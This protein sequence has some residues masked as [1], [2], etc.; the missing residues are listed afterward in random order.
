MRT[1][2]HVGLFC[3]FLSALAGG[4]SSSVDGGAEED[5]GEVANS[6]C[7]AVTV[8]SNDADDEAVPGQS[9]TWTGTPTCS[10]SAQYQFWFR[11]PQTGVWGLAQDWSSTNTYVWNT[12]GLV[13]GVWQMQLWVRDLPAG[14]FQAYVSHPF[15]LSSNA[16]CTAVSSSR[17]PAAGVAGTSVTFANSASTCPGPEYAIYRMAPGGSW[18]LQSAY[19]TANANYVWNSTGAATGVHQFQIWARQQGSAKSY[20]AY[21]STNFTVLSSNP[22]TSTNLTFSPVGHAPAGTAV[23]LNATAAGCAAP[24]FRY[25]L[26]PAASATW[27]ELQPYTSSATAT[28]NTTLLTP[29]TYNFQ[30]WARN[31]GSTQQFQAYVSK[32]YTLDVST[33]P[34]SLAIGGGYA[35]NCTILST[36]KVGCWGY[37]AKGELGNGTIGGLSKTPVAVTGL[38]SGISLGVGYEHG[39]AVNVGGT[40]SCWGQNLHGQLGNGG[41][42]NSGSPVA[43]SGITNARNIQSGNSHNCVALADGTVKCWGFNSQGQ[44]GDGSKVDRTT[45]VSVPGITT[46]QAVAAGYYHSCALLADGSVQCW[47][48]GGS[49]GNGSAVGSLMPVTVSGL[50]GVTSINASSGN[51]CAVKS[52]GTIWCWG[53]NSAY[54][55]LGN[56]T[57]TAQL[58]PVQ[59]TG[60]TTATAVAVGPYHACAALQNGTATCWGYNVYGQLGNGT[61]V[62]SLAP[63]A[64]SNLTTVK[65]VG[66]AQFDSCAILTDGSARCWGYN[67][68][69]SLGNNSTAHSSVPVTVAAIP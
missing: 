3:I 40:V 49:L 35:Q 2:Q 51:T 13:T 38:T 19:S 10:G 33:T 62:D 34:G 20:Q 4:C 58:S 45:P 16:A 43:V 60:I 57:T 50:S 5:L 47:G 17:S 11:N 54:G 31:S 12:T 56:G 7:S 36:G 1:G 61:K 69:G 25:F 42:A 24:T 37:N 23:A 65:S 6:L 55:T 53:G 67:S 14:K 30:L 68:L 66:I 27:Q 52:D 28:W 48:Q 9:V 59:V 18:Q 8:I 32:N 63:V 39:C 64:V 21:Q 44:L 41:T 26:K 22:C 46:A 15:T 29:G